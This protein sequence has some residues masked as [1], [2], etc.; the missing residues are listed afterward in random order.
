V[1]QLLL[2]LDRIGYTPPNF[3]RPLLS[4]ISFDLA[5][6]E[7]IT[8]TG[9]TGA[10]KSTL[11]R[12]LNRLADPTSGEILLNGKNYR[13]LQPIALRQQIMLV[14]QEPKLLDMKVRDALAYPL[15]LRSIAPAEIERKIVEITE[16]FQI[17][18][19]WFDRPA[20]Q[21][22]AG[23]KKLIAIVRGA[24]VQPQILMLDEP[25]ANF[26]F[27]SAERI[28]GII[29]DFTRAHQIGTIIVDRQLELATRCS[30]RLLYLQAGRLL[31]DRSTA[32]GDWQDL[33]HQIRTAERQAIAEWE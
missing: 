13:D 20:S 27:I 18:I 1:S 22:T 25:I 6:G 17:P 24:I 10:G 33:Q 2:R 7:I 9:I 26:D 15:Q 4:D 21:L 14:P 32:A 5:A 16:L 31:V 8:L 11:L 12:L 23:E 28:L 19:D 30:D 3:T 29:R